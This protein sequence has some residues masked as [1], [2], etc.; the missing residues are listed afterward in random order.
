MA[1]ITFTNGFLILIE[2]DKSDKTEW[3]KAHKWQEDEFL[4]VMKFGT[5][6]SMCYPNPLEETEPFFQNGYKY[7]FLIENDWGPVTLE[8]MTTGKKRAIKYL[9]IGKTFKD[10]SPEDEDEDGV[11]RPPTPIKSKISVRAS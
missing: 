1:S 9:E 11:Y 4:K 6:K 2:G 10:I 7:R 8:N 3:F 5:M